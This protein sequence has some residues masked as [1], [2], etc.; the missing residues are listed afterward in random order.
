M[1]NKIYSFLGLAMKAGK[2]ISGEE[3][4]ER[5]LKSGKVFLIILAE[6][7]S[8]NNRKKFADMC[9]YRNVAIRFF[10]EKE[11]IGRYI[12]KSVRTVIAVSD[13]GFSKRLIELIDTQDYEGG[14]EQVGES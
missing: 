14:G 10:G 13:E 2:L 3:P 12:G 6:D 9:Q 5:A 1:E 4:C 7:T 11:K 8:Y